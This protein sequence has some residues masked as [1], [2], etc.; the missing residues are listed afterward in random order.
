[1]ESITTKHDCSQPVADTAV[2]LFDDWFDPIEAA[3][4]DR[5]RG[6]IQAVI[7]DELA[8]TLERPRYGRA[9][10]RRTAMIA[11]SQSAVTGTAIGHGR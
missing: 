9:R 5:V 10:S 2:H 7:E 11:G 8:G 4:R 3:V 6:F 1:M